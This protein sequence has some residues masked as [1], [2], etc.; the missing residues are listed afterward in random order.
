MIC[1]VGVALKNSKRLQ[2]KERQR[3]RENKSCF[4]NTKEFYFL[5]VEIFFLFF[6]FSGRNMRAEQRNVAQRE[7]ERE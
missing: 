4:E 5:Y 3:E 1:V 2:E 7:R 6:N